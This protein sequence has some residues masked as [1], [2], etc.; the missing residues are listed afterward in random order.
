MKIRNAKRWVKLRPLHAYGIGLGATAAAFLIRYAAHGVLQAYLPFQLSV[1]ATILVEF[2]CGFG[3]AMLPFVIGLVA[4]LYFFIPPFDSFTIL[5][6]SDLV[7]LINY[8]AVTLFLVVLIEW[9]RRSEYSRELLLRVSDSR[10]C[11][12]LHRDNARLFA[13][14]AMARMVREF[15][16]VLGRL[17]RVWMIYEP[18]GHCLAGAKLLHETPLDAASA[19]GEDLLNV[20][21]PEDRPRV[22]EQFS[23]ASDSEP[24]QRKLRFRIL[25]RD[26]EYSERDWALYRLQTQKRTYLVLAEA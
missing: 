21:H 18:G 24:A 7:Y 14:R 19:Q 4:S 13:N 16:A 22:A 8:I 26:G 6:F 25:G 20:V 11:M 9:L 3:P 17:D 1:I 5:E 23:E 12:M 2:F 15:G 10:Y